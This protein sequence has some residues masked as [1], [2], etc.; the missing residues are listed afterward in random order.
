[1][2]SINDFLDRLT[3][4][5]CYTR[6]TEEVAKDKLIYGLN[7]EVR[8]R[9]AQTLQ[10]PKSLHEQIV[11]LYDIRHNHENFKIL[12]NLHQDPKLQNKN[13]FQNKGNNNTNTSC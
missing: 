7:N 11:L 6:Y 5:M 8:L 3:S 1:M 13:G 12:N 4:L 2:D 10:K 9:W